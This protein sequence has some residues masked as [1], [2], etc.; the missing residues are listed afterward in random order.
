MAG[1]VYLKTDRFEVKLEGIAFKA[2]DVEPLCTMDFLFPKGKVWKH[3]PVVGLDV[4]RH[5][6]DPNIAL[7]LLCFGTGCAI[8]RFYVGK[9]LADPILKFLQDKRIS[10]VGFGIPEKKD[11]FPFDKL[12]LKESD[13]DVGFLAAKLLNDPKLKKYE[14][15]DLARRVLGIKT[16]VGVTKARSLGMHRQIKCAICEVFVST[17]ISMTLLHPKHETNLVN[18]PKKSLLAKNLDLSS[19][20]IEKWSRMATRSKEN[21]ESQTKEGKNDVHVHCTREVQSSCDDPNKTGASP[22][23]KPLKGILKCLS[24]GQ[25]KKRKACPNMIF[26]KEYLDLVLVP[27]GLLLMFGYHLYILHKY[28]HCP[29]TTIFDFEYNDKKDWVDKV[30]KMPKKDNALTVLGSNTNAATFLASVSLTLSSLIGAWIANNSSIFQSQL[31]YGDT[32]SSTMSIKYISLLICFILAF[33]CFIQSARC[34]IHSNYLLSAP[35]SNVPVK[36]VELAVTRGGDFWSLGLRALYF[37][38]NMLLWFFGPIPMFATSVV[39]V[40]LLY[41]LDT[42]TTLLHRLKYPEKRSIHL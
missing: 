11:L 36:Y 25:S 27:S 40:L 32:R 21:N 34:F 19:I 41:Y 3:P 15:A 22:S 33:S 16:M 5:P 42:N 31:I 24:Q 10:F 12:G 23:N 35:D 7:L 39:M 18:S 13:V 2:R 29:N 14:L 38:I 9:Q 20:F 1:T 26:Q 37:A 28:L 17:V 6:R 30:I 8:I 4:L